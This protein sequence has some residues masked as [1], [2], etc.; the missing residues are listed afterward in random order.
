MKT[1]SSL[2]RP[3]AGAL[4]SGRVQALPPG[5]FGEAADFVAK[6]HIPV[7]KARRM[8]RF[9]QLTLASAIE[10]IG[11]AGLSVSDDNS[12]ETAVAVGTGLASTD[13]TDRFYEGLLREGPEGTNPMV[14]PET[15]QNIGASH[16]AM[17]FGI[18]GPNTTFSQADL[19]GDLALFFGYELLRDG[20]ADYAIVSG[21]D[22]L[23]LASVTGYASLGLLAD[24]MMPF[25]A[26]RSGFVLAEGGATIVLERYE[27]ARKRGAHIYG[28][29]GAIAFSGAPVPHLQYDTSVRSMTAAMGEAC[30]AAGIQQPGFI[31]ASANSTRDL[32][33]CEAMAIEEVWGSGAKDIPVTAPRSLYGFFHGDS[34]LRIVVTLLCLQEGIIPNISG[35]E[36]PMPGCSLDFVSDGPRDTAVGSALVNTF[37]AGGSAVSTVLRKVP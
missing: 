32:D 13:S 3:F 7:M 17:H 4:Q 33:H 22:E 20:L 9:S 36:E 28:I 11:D 15:V 30:A 6:D 24:R 10:A 26:G 14:F 29:I 34:I 31:S 25:D 16:I 23:S 19:S 21:A 5:V 1:V 8:S 18:R 37:S 2:R 27:E 35:L 12:F